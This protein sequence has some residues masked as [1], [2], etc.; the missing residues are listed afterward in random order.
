MNKA[1]SEQDTPQMR[2]VVQRAEMSHALGAPERIYQAGD[3]ARARYNRIAGERLVAGE[4]AAPEDIVKEVVLELRQERMREL[5]AELEAAWVRIGAGKTRAQFREALLSDD[6]VRK[7]L[8]E[9]NGYINAHLADVD[10][11]ASKVTPSS[12]NGVALAR[13]KK[14]LMDQKQKFLALLPSLASAPPP[15]PVKPAPD[16]TPEPTNPEPEP[17]MASASSPAAGWATLSESIARVD[18]KLTAIEA[19]EG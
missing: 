13:I 6:S 14:D 5:D 18:A 16:E 9:Y 4:S 12:A 3:L 19:A 17:A 15:A 2:R 10:D 11:A 1:L 7:V 8:D